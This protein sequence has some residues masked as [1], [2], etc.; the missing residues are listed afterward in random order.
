MRLTYYPEPE[1]PVAF[2]CARVGCFDATSRNG[3]YCSGCASLRGY[4]RH[5]YTPNDLYELAKHA[6]VTDHIRPS[7]N[8]GER[9]DAAYCAM[10]EA[11]WSSVEPVSARELV[12]IGRAASSN[13]IAE[14]MR[15]HGVDK[16]AGR[17]GEE[18]VNFA[19]FWVDLPGDSTEDRIVNRTSLAQIWPLLKPNHQEALTALAVYGDYQ[20]AADALGLRYYTFCARVRHGRLTFLSHWHEG[21]MPSTTWGNDRR[22]G[23]ETSRTAV[24]VLAHRRRCRQYAAPVEDSVQPDGETA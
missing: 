1:A 17:F 21:E 8:W 18:R 19:R 14:D 7:I 22:R 5:G 4:E 6:V 24:R 13:V 3:S 16:R 20:R 23:R 2:A 11:V 9:V 12:F 10:T 15:H